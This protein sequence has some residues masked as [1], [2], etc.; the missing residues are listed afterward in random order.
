MSVSWH[1][2]IDAAGRYG[3][4][5]QLYSLPPFLAKWNDK[6]RGKV[7]R[8]AGYRSNKLSP[9]LPWGGGV[10]LG[11]RKFSYWL[12]PSSTHMAPPCHFAFLII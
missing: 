8:L 2:S 4:E 1:Q 3:R 6:L 11:P 5:V 7:L 9:S 10:M 12:L